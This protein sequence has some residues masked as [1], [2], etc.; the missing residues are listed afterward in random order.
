SG[1]PYLYA[2]ETYGPL[3]G[4][5]VGWLVWLARVTSFSANC[6]LLPNYLDLLIPGA[7]A[8]VPRM[9]ILTI[10]VTGLAILNIRGVRLV[11][12]ASNV[13]ALGKLLPLAVFVAAGMFFLEPA[14]FTAAASPG[15]HA[16][17]QAVMLLVYAFTGFEMAVIP[18]G[19]VR[20]PQHNLPAALLTGMAAVV[21]F[22]VL[23]QV[24]CIGTLPGLATSQRPLGDAIERFLGKGGAVMITAGILVSLAGNLNVLILAGSR[25]MYAMAEHGA[26]PATLA[27][28]DPRYRTP[29]VSVLATTAVMLALTLSGTFIYLVTVSTVVRLATYLITCGALPILRRRATAP[30]AA[31]RMPGGAVVSVLAMAVSVWLL[32]NVSLHEARDSGIAV[33]AGLAIF[34]LHLWR[35]RK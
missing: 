24:V 35:K 23:I 10:T 7:A 13:L 17:S 21:T 34:G 14:R 30:P 3:T 18:A 22:Y 5:T 20:N 4:F 12:N 32:S 26:L 6:T 27:D 31:F 15:Y 8:G 9:C 2:L 25:V 29:V 33:A 16:F 11:A 19:E 28:I 1:G